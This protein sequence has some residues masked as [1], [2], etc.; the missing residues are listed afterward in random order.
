MKKDLTM[1]E[2]WNKDYINKEEVIPN[3]MI[4]NNKA[5]LTLKLTK[6]EECTKEVDR[7]LEELYIYVATLKTHPC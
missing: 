6:A 7:I 2:Q 3:Y 5:A 4:E 1:L